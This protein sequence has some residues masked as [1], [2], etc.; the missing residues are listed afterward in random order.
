MAAVLSITS[1]EIKQFVDALADD[2]FEGRE[3]GTR[4]NRAAG[5]Y[6]IERLKKLGLRGGGPKGSFYQPFGTY[7]QH[8]GHRRRQRPDA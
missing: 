1:E 7:S 3:A 8:S 4:G 6:M 5:I 2:T